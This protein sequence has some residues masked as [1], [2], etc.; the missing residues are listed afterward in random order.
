MNLR[1]ASTLASSLRPGILPT[2]TLARF[3]I[4]KEPK[5]ARDTGARLSVAVA[6]RGA[7]VLRARATAKATVTAT[8]TD[9][10]IREEAHLSLSSS[11]ASSA[12]SA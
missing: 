4:A 3:L 7:A 10:M 5:R 11:A 6:A 1:M 8:G 9:A 2:T 12:V